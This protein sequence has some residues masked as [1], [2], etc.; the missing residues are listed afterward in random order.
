MS[1]RAKAPTMMNGFP[2]ELRLHDATP[3]PLGVRSIPRKA[4]SVFARLMAGTTIKDAGKPGSP[5]RHRGTFT[6]RRRD[7]GLRHY[8]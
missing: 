1:P 5:G 4:R 3:K 7:M 8:A 2:A 6:S